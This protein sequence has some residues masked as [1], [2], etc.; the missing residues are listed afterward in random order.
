MYLTSCPSVSG[1]EPFEEDVE[2]LLVDALSAIHPPEREEGGRFRPYG[3]SDNWTKRAETTGEEDQNI[4]E[5]LAVS[6]SPTDFVQL[7]VECR[8]SG[9]KDRPIRPYWRGQFQDG[10]ETSFGT[11]AAIHLAID[12]GYRLTKR[13][14][15]YVLDANISGS[16]K[17]QVKAFAATIDVSNLDVWDHEIIEGVL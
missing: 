12:L 1:F 4:C 8:V 3:G 9:A 11:E 15:A 16:K 5:L 10:L 17:E 14:R 13:G 6:A 7:E 2:P